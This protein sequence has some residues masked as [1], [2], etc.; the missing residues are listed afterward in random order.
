MSKQENYMEYAIKEANKAYLKGEIPVGAI[1]LSENK[2][3]IARAHN[4][5]EKTNNVSNHAE[6]LVIEK[7]L[8]KTNLRFLQNCEIWVT[9]EPCI[10]CFSLICMTRLKKLY[11]GAGSNSCNK[12]YS[13]NLN[14]LS[15][16]LEHKIEIYQGFSENIC[17][18]LIKKFFKNLR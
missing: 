12:C 1:I 7:A 11:F 2:K 5:I 14:T 13:L 8:K 15:K 4:L 9:L 10:M 16:K 3:I 17:S 18:N 6:K